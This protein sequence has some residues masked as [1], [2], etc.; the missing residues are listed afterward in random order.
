MIDTVQQ[1]AG[2]IN[3]I[4]S[5]LRGYYQTSITAQKSKCNG[6]VDRAS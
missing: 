3:I 6:R 1:Q 2:V 5:L 4:V